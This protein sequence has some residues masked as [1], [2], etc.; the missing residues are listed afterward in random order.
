MCSFTRRAMYASPLSI[1]TRA[2]GSGTTIGRS[3]PRRSRAR[4]SS[5]PASRSSFTATTP[6]PAAMHAWSAS[7]ARAGVSASRTSTPARRNPVAVSPSVITAILYIHE[8]PARDVL[9]NAE[10]ARVRDDAQ[11]ADLGALPREVS[12]H[13]VQR[14]RIPHV[15]PGGHPHERLVDRPFHLRQILGPGQVGAEQPHRRDLGEA[16]LRIGER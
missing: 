2:G 7:R 13:H 16:R 10:L 11:V 14:E 3:R 5:V 12:D 6:Y 15:H 4:A 8:L 9:G 1:S